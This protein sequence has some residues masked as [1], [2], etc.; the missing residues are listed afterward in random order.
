LPVFKSP[1]TEGWHEKLGDFL[2]NVIRNASAAVDSGMKNVAANRGIRDALDIGTARRVATPN[3]D[4]V[5]VKENGVTK[6][7]ELDDPLL[8]EA[9]KG[10]NLPRM[11]WVQILAKPADDAS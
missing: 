11:P 3:R 4:S 2:E 5:S 10:L 9:F 1:G 8:F 7:Y 6:H